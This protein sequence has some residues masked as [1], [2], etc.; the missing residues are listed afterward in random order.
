MTL[1]DPSPVWSPLR[2]D[3]TPSAFRV[4]PSSASSPRIVVVFA[5][6]FL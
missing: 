2:P 4:L 1:N 3:V 6:E 5:V